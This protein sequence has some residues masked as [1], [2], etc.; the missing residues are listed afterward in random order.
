MTEAG[1]GRAGFANGRFQEPGRC[2]GPCGGPTIPLPRRAGRKAGGPAWVRRARAGAQR[3]DRRQPLRAKL[4]LP[5]VHQKLWWSFRWLTTPHK[6][7]AE[8]RSRKP[9][10]RGGQSVS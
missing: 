6:L 4:F 9:A 3:N 7:Q 1:S 2:E 8:A 10:R 5:A